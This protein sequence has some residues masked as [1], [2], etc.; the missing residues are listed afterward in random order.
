[1]AQLSRPYQ[2]ALGALLLLVLVWVAVGRR[3][4]SSEPGS[5]ASTPTTATHAAAPSAGASA[6]SAGAAGSSKPGLGA[7]EA[8]SA[9]SPT[10]IYHGKTPGL[11]GL[12]RDVNK[13]HEAV[14]TSQGEA[15]TV[16][17]KSA[18]ASGEAPASSAA[19]GSGAASG[20]A[21]SPTSP[22]A[23]A[24][25]GASASPSSSASSA[26]NT[27]VPPG[28]RAV[29]AALAQG[30]V[31]IVLFWNPDGADD[32]AVHGQVQQLGHSHLPISVYEGNAEAVASFGAI[33]REVPVYGTPT[34]LIVAKNGQTTELTGLQ[35]DFTIERAIE[36]ARH[37]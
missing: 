9:A 18:Q 14:A 26:G 8:K 22:S 24:P 6:S 3:H 33:T 36:E 25:S 32:L 16:E 12:S 17:E 7:A 10:P 27:L 30:K 23:S 31:P 15:K 11:E 2:I 1:M 37:A 4:G 28:Q 20:A 21:K 35:E 34:I 13:A 5:A 19:A 29:E